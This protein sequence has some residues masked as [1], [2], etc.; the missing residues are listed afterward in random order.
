MP[1]DPSAQDV[2]ELIERYLEAWIAGDT[3]D[4]EQMAA[5]LHSPRERMRFRASA[6]AQEYLA[7][8]AD[9]RAVT[10]EA[11]LERLTSEPERELFAR[12]LSDSD[13]ARQRLP[14]ELLPGA[15]LDGRYEILR[16]VGRGGMGVV[17]A[18]FDRELER[19]VALKVLQIP[20]R[21]EA[22]WEELFQRES[23]TL[24]RLES[25]NIVAI[26]DARRGAERSY[27]VMDLVRGQD[28]ERVLKQLPVERAALGVSARSPE[29]LRRVVGRVQGGERVDLLGERTHARCVGRILR[30]VVFTVELAHGAGVIHRDL[31]PQNVLI[32]PGGEPVL[33]DFGLASWGENVD[34]AFRGTPEYLAPE[35]I[36]NMRTGK[37][38][39]TDVY[40]LGLLLY[41]LLSLRRAF[42]RQDEEDVFA[43]FQ[44]IA[45]GRS[46]ALTELASGT[47]PALVAIAR[48]AMEP[49]PEG[50]YASVRELREDLDRFI[51]R[52][53]PRH[54]HLSGALR[55]RLWLGYLLLQPWT[56]VALVASLALFLLL[57]ASPWIPPDLAVLMAG[58]GQLA[59]LEE[60]Q[61]I[62]FR[63]TCVLGLEATLDSPAVLYTFSV[64]GD[65]QDAETQFLSP[66]ETMSMDD[67][68]AGKS[69]ENAAEH[70]RLEP[71]RH[72]L[73]CT[74]LTRPRDF[75]GLLIF[76]CATPNELLARWQAQLTESERAT[77]PVRY[78]D[79][80]RAREL[81]QQGLR[82][83]PL[84]TLSGA[85][86]ERIFGSVLA[87]ERGDEQQALAAGIRRYRFV[88][89]VQHVESA[90]AGP[91]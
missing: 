53:P 62:P 14:G 55:A 82:G 83:E 18:A 60:G 4:L 90:G 9:G 74:L 58:E 66:A 36:R 38:P 85:E 78:E 86:R 30:E 34:D 46:P 23:R 28:L 11:Y 77:G 17:Y 1:R 42:P 32:V 52:K 6:L 72:R 27:I 50:R 5:G 25:R 33:L 79:A 35:Q 69:A 3:P 84:G 73:A 24:A 68:M 48:K 54:A 43:L 87:A 63:G 13:A 20:A 81:L 88:F 2:E 49:D 47:P 59:T 44:R 70:P 40:Q 16:E 21:V 56:A 65:Q 71:G 39:R 89:P 57:R 22:G 19:E 12:V 15:C 41:E 31:K 61:P 26:H 64:Y 37:D 76:A 7:S 8:R 10:R 51:G 91:R 75:E 80:L 29:P 45:Q 67:F